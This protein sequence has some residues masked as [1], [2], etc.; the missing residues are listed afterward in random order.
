MK[1][2]YLITGVIFLVVIAIALSVQKT[3]ILK[4]IFL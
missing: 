4:K 1:K 3:I 2:M